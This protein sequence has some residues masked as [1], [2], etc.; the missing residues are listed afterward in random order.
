MWWA[1]TE[2]Y[3]VYV[4]V[5]SD[6]PIAGRQRN[7]VSVT[8]TERDDA[9]SGLSRFRQV[10]GRVDPSRIPNVKPPMRSFFLDDANRIWVMPELADGETG[11]VLE[12]Y[13]E[14]GVQQAAGP[15]SPGQVGGGHAEQAGVMQYEMNEN[16]ARPR[17]RPCVEAGKHVVR[18]AGDHHGHEPQQVEMNVNE[19]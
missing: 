14:H 18:H 13:D 2:R 7:A 19:A 15:E 10:G 11:R 3:A 4:G 16:A 1:W 17:Y 8:K 5:E 9:L 6:R 12:V